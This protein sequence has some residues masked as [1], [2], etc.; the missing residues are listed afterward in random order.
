VFNFVLGLLL[1]S[2][3]QLQTQR[4]RG[5]RV[6][7]P[8]IVYRYHGDIRTVSAFVLGLPLVLVNNFKPSE[9]E[10]REFLALTSF[11]VITAKPCWLSAGLA[12]LTLS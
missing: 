5:E 6:L 10:E 12:N 8:N 11:I 7:S 2:G 3:Q 1:A 4:R 9:E